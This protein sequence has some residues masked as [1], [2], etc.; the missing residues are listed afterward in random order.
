LWPLAI[1]FFFIPQAITV[2]E[3]SRHFPGEGAVYVWPSRLLGGM[4]GF[5]SGWCYWM[6]NVVYVPTLV[7]SSVGLAAYMFGA[8]GSALASQGVPIELGTFS[9]GIILIGL[10]T[11]VSMRPGASVEKLI[12]QPSGFDWHLVSVFSLLCFS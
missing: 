8:S 9:V 1:M 7:V 6:A 2:I 10:T 3:L 12:W 5:L 11:W 4:H